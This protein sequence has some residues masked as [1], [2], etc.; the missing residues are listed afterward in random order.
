MIASR[1]FGVVLFS[2]A[3]A[4]PLAAQR[5]SDTTRLGDLVVTAT[6]APAPGIVV[7]AATTILRGDDLRARGIT[8]V[9]DALREVP[10]M[11]LVQTGSYGAVTALFLRG[12]EGDYVKV[13]LDGVTLNQPGGGFNFANLTTDDLD[14]IEIVRG[15][16]SVLYGADAMSGVVQL[17][18]R[19]GAG[20]LHGDLTATA[21]SFGNRDGAVHVAGGNGPLTVSA[22]ASSFRS[23]GIYDFNSGYRDRVGSLRIGLDGGR[24]GS[25]AFTLRIGDALGHYPTDG[26]GVPVDHNQYTAD[27]STVLGLEFHRALSAR[28]RLSGQLASSRLRS[29]A[30]NQPDGSADTVGFGF[31]ADRTGGTLRRG[32]DLRADWTLH[33][34]ALVSLGTGIEH[35]NEDQQSRTVSNFGSGVFTQSDEFAANRN[36]RNV[37]S[38]LLARPFSILSIQVGARLDDNSAFG[39]FST[40]R[41]GASWQLGRSTRAYSAA[42]TAFKAPTFSELFAASAFEVG[43]RALRP[44]RSRNVELGIEQQ[45]ARA[46]L[47]L[48]ATLFSQRFRDLIQYVGAAPGEPTYTNL[49]GAQARGVEV[50]AS[51]RPISQLGLKGHWSWLRTEV[52]DTGSASSVVFTQGERLLRR[53]ASSGGL[54][55]LLGLRGATVGLGITYAGSRD[56]ADFRDFP[57][58]RT[59]L[60]SYTL[61]DLSLDAPLRATRAGVP[62]VDL[63]LRAENL[64]NSRWSQVVGFPGRGRTLVGGARVHF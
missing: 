11:M 54:T 41:V 63:T 60:P 30:F 12:G 7:P 20:R 8:L 34:D 10:G 62:G 64:L 19:K 53:P 29:D 36:T 13:L 14:R 50:G 47:V 52:T 16:A 9:A 6:R 39:T 31:D 48:T 40:W 61:V 56:D 18:T 3:V 17:F 25:A 49:G 21:G 57:A 51:W 4:C 58:A 15:P 55:A 23:D 24:V 45:L 38:Q 32:A 28:F 33:P 44:E 37:Y 35:E 22:S 1:V 59:T 5:S 42:G 26:N 2:V 43:N 46:R 27:R